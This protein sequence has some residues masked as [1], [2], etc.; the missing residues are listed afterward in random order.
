MRHLPAARRN[1]QPEQDSDH[2]AAAANRSVVLTASGALRGP[3][4]AT[5]RIPVDNSELLKVDVCG[6][7]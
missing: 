7:L 3:R 1:V 2:C 4:T 6:V 5:C